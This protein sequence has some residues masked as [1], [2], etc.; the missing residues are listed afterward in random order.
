M[1]LALCNEVLRHR[2]FASQ[3]ERAAALGYDGLEVAP[4][5]LAD[6]PLAMTVARRAQ[7]RRAANEAGVAITGLHWLLVKPDGLSVTH[8]DVAVR[9][10]TI[11]AMRRLV[12][13]CVD[14]GGRY[15][16]HGSPAQRRTPEGVPP[17]TARAWIGE[18]LAAVAPLAEQ[19]GVLYL[20]EPLP[21]DETDQVN[22]LDEAAALVRAVGS[23]AVATMLDTK[24]ASL[25]ETASPAELVARWLPTGLLRHVQLNDRNRRAP[26]QGRDRFD[27]VLAALADGGYDGDLAVEPFDYV[28]DGDGCAAFAAGY[29]RGVLDSVRA[30]RPS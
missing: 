26:G 11:E 29:V 3:C 6:D 14:L 12:A 17:A 25:A 13:L 4:F 24:S 1:R 5:T 2:D 30:R 27:A 20:V 18:A 22:T 7:A 10:R 19:A 15:L 21:R 8:P 16:V 28:P 9:G 23:P